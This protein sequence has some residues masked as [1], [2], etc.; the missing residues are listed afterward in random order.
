MPVL[1]GISREAPELCARFRPLN[2]AALKPLV[3]SDKSLIVR[4]KEAFRPI[5]E[6]HVA[7][8]QHFLSLK[9]A[10]N[11]QNVSGALLSRVATALG[12]DLGGWDPDYTSAQKV[13]MLLL[14]ATFARLFDALGRLHNA[15]PPDGM[16]NLIALLKPNWFAAD[17]AANFHLAASRGAER[18]ASLNASKA[19]FTV[20]D[21]IQRA[22][23]HEQ[24]WPYCLLSGYSGEDD[25]G[26]LLA[27]VREWLRKTVENDDDLDDVSVR[28]LL[29][30][31]RKP[32]L[33]IVLAPSVTANHPPSSE[34]LTRLRNDF[35]HCIFLM[36][37]GENP[38]A[39]PGL[40][41]IMPV[42]EA[43]VE[44]TAYND[45]LRLRMALGGGR[46]K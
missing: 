28:T 35:P 19:T 38:I 29:A 39:I 17:T 15:I 5:R 16:E 4:I 10:Q 2:I 24:F 7:S 1:V 11:L 14:Q 40:T 23:A 33:I 12:E 26:A 22:V 18:G 13:A 41:Q 32:P 21:L 30:Q 9:I 37:T 46:R 6:R 3:A 34:A 8:P 25:A 36:L 20:P 43:G 27:G 31:P 42:L 45:W 44:A